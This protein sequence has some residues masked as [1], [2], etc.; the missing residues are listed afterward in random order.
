MG[1]LAGRVSQGSGVAGISHGLVA[2][3]ELFARAHFLSG[4][5][6]KKL[7]FLFTPKMFSQVLKSEFWNSGSDYPKRATGADG[8]IEADD[9]R[10]HAAPLHG[11]EQPWLTLEGEQKKKPAVQWG[12][13]TTKL[14]HNS[15]KE[16]SFPT[17]SRQLQ[18][19]R[20]LPRAVAGANRG[21]VADG[22]GQG[23]AMHG[24]ELPF[25]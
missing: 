15:K 19:L 20:P 22:V 2:C 14:N 21:V 6:K 17:T 12:M 16:K 24:P 5:A 1:R 25:G 3:P 18:R 13:S 11:A 4:L 9:R 7:N 10:P 23:R 8:G